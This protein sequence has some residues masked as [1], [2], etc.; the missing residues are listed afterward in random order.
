MM[1]KEIL[2]KIKEPFSERA[3]DIYGQLRKLGE[4]IYE[5]RAPRK[6][7]DYRMRAGRCITRVLKYLRY[8]PY[9]GARVSVGGIRGNLF[10]AYANV[11]YAL[12]GIDETK[13]PKVYQA[14]I[15]CLAAIRSLE[16]YFDKTYQEIFP[17][18]SIK[19][20]NNQLFITLNFS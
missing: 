11:C 7:Y 12:K 13:N 9:I 18:G 2:D 8:W 6:C 1:C 14:A 15:K 17:N 20:L 5:T 4:T 19:S 10:L 16:K 3:R